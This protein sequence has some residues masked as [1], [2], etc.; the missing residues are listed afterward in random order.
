MACRSMYFSTVKANISQHR[1]QAQSPGGLA[2]VPASAS[3]VARV[4]IPLSRSLLGISPAPANLPSVSLRR[5]HSV[6]IVNTLSERGC[7]HNQAKDTRFGNALC[8]LPWALR[9]GPLRDDR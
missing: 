7:G 5:P 6:L 1:P 4:L 3:W 9:C 2:G 8:V